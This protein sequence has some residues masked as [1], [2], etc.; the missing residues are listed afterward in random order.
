MLL[1]NVT[2]G[3]AQWVGEKLGPSLLQRLLPGDYF[4][5]GTWNGKKKKSAETV[6]A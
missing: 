5:L 4:L 2:L 1:V 3:L 6:F